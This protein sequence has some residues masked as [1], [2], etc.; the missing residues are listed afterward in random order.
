MLIPTGI[1]L[2]SNTEIYPN[3]TIFTASIQ[4]EKSS[5]AQVDQKLHNF[6]RPLPS[7]PDVPDR[8]KGSR[9]AQV[10]SLSLN[11]D[12]HPR[13][14]KDLGPGPYRNSHG[15]T[16]VALVQAKGLSLQSVGFAK[17]IPQ[18]AI[19]AGYLVDRQP[20]KGSVFITSESSDLGPDTGHAGIVL[21]DQD[22]NYIYVEEQNY[23][24]GHLTE[25]WLPRSRIVA[26]IHL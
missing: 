18:L 23:K 15:A 17:N 5:V 24:G 21:G 26:I 7:L 20:A 9:I 8:P 6:P 3:S 11:D 19:S 22:P 1:R 10:A 2:D 14:A 16:C 4:R 12:N 13:V 25:G